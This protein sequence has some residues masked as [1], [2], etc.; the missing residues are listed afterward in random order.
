MADAHTTPSAAEPGTT[1]PE[2][3]YY[4]DNL[5]VLLTVLVVLHHAAVTYG[6]IPIWF[7][8]E[9]AQDSSGA[10]LDLLVV[11]NQT[12]FMGF[13]FLIAGFLVP[14]SY[15]RKGPRSFLRGR[16]VRLGIPLLLFL[17]LLRP[18]L[19]LGGY[20]G[21]ASGETPYWLFYL[22]TWDP[23]P[24]WFVETLLV[25]CLGYALIRQVRARR[26]PAPSGDAAARRGRLPGPAW[27]LAGAAALIVL[28][29]L[30][31]ILVPAGSY[32]PVV[33]LPSP[34]Y[35]PQYALL[36]AA[37]VLAFR[38]GWFD[39]IPRSAGLSG[40]GAAVVA[41]VAFA[42]A[43]AV[44]GEAAMESGSWQSLLIAALENTFGLGIIC[45]LLWLFQ[46][47]FNRQRAWGRFLSANAYGVYFLHPL[48]L[49]ALGYAF[50]GRD[51]PAIAKFTAVGA[52]AL[53]LCWAA[54]GLMRSLP[55]AKRVF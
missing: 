12:F 7:Y 25:F 26:A 39:R 8:T 14:A 22:L 18:L 45:F 13:F 47:R 19:T 35:L 37:G 20:L 23:G 55:H 9:P 31:R 38:G 34:A 33:G 49:V 28:T 29:Y 3:L 2:R 16:L 15:D 41:L 44:A 53:P 11:L 51:A 6:N 42:P 30:W 52:L 32:W 24:M 21:D 17:L 36:F 27:V 48:I 46:R 4:L 1:A 5:R 54:A 40:L 10:L 43:A 50:S